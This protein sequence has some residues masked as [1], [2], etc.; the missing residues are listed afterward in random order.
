[1][2]PLVEHLGCKLPHL[3]ENRIVELQPPVARKH[4]NCFGK[5]IE[6]LALHADQ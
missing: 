2:R 4:R 1:M 5:V 3:G 6:R